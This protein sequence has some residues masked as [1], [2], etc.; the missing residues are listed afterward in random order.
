MNQDPLYL[1]AKLKQLEKLQIMDKATLNWI[2]TESLNRVQN[3]E[4]ICPK[5]SN[6]EFNE[7]QSLIPKKEDFYK[8]DH[9]ISIHGVS[10]I[11]RV[12]IKNQFKFR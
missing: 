5:I 12:M 1:R 9:Y 10:H 3:L 6:D 8:P 4:L 2:E 7:I 11:L